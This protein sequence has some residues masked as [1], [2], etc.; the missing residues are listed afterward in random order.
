MKELDQVIMD[1]KWLGE[2]L[3]RYQVYPGMEVYVLPKPGYIKK[4]AIFSTRF[5]S[6]DNRYRVEGTEEIQ[7]LPDGVAHFLE[8]KL[9]KMN[10]QCFRPVC[11]LGAPP[12]PLP[13][14]PIP[15]TCF[16]V[17]AFLRRTL[18]CC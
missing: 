5:G 14:L 12:M 10:G 3:Y 9:L 8:H 16:P 17:P 11:Q 18:S 7:Q 6:I 2:R 4:Y 1:N 13:L 15:P